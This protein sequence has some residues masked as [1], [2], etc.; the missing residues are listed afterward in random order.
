M[1]RKM[2]SRNP[3]VSCKRP[4]ERVMQ[5][6][7]Y[8]LLLVPSL[9]AALFLSSCASGPRNVSV[10]ST[11]LGAV[12]Y[13]DDKELGTT[14]FEATIEERQGDYNIYEFYA[15][16]KDYLPERRIYKEEFYYEDVSDAVPDTIHFTMRLRA[17]HN[18]SVTSNPTGATVLLDR[19]EYGITP[20]TLSFE[21]SIKEPRSFTIQVQKDGYKEASEV[22][23]EVVSEEVQGAFELPGE[24]HFA[25]EQIVDA[26]Q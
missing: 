18:I 25:L 14:P 13:L 3:Y 23:T 4:E 22:V 19:V 21:S 9:L 12:V 20:F 26:V 11:P 17:K 5:R 1:A 24:V 7:R 15:V 10:T 6:N 16:K 8:R 2:F